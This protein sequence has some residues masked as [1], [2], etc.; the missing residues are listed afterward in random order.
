MSIIPFLFLFISFFSP[1]FYFTFFLLI[2]YFLF[3][4]C[5]SFLPYPFPA[6]VVA[7]VAPLPP[8]LLSLTLPNLQLPSGGLQL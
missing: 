7:P 3:F 5:N 8:R 6:W 2:F 1:I 4:H